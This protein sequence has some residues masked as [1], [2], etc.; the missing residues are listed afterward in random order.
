MAFNIITYLTGLT[1]FVFDKSVLER[2]ATERG[3]SGVTDYSLLEQETK[4]LLLADLLF[5]AYVSPNTSA[6]YSAS[7]GSYKQSIGSQRID[8]KSDIYNI[9]VGLYKKWGEEDKLLLLTETSSNKI[10]F[11]DATGLMV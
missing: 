10:D 2:I 5:T 1:G 7:H 4:D 6:S 9:M 8:N 3:V 11:I